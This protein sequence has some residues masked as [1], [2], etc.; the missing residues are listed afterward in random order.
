MLSDL[1]GI[2]CRLS[3]PQWGAGNRPLGFASLF[4]CGGSTY[5]LRT[6]FLL[7]YLTA[8]RFARSVIM[9]GTVPPSEQ[10]SCERSQPLRL[11]RLARHLLRF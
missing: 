11:V 3:T 10:R 8:A 7:D 6:L 5:V 2:W 4:F 1:C 9:V